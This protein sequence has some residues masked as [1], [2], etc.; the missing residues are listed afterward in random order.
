MLLAMDE[1]EDG[2]T[3]ASALHEGY[4][5]HVPSYHPG[6]GSVMSDKLQLGFFT[7]RDS[8]KIIE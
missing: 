4:N 1:Y 5:K 2:A 6:C 8:T 3:I 7:D